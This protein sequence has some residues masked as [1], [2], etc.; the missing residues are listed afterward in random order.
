[1]FE[2]LDHKHR[3]GGY[4][5]V[6]AKHDRVVWAAGDPKRPVKLHAYARALPTTGTWSIDVSANTGRRARKTRVRLAAGKLTLPVPRPACGE[7]G[8]QPLEVW[9][10][11]VEEIDPPP[12][13]EKPLEWVL[14]SNLPCPS[15]G[16]ARR[17]V[18][19][20]ARRPVIEEFHKAQKTGCGIE[21]PQLTDESR[22][23][24]LIALLSIV[25]VFLLGLRDAAG[26]EQSARAPAGGF[27]PQSHLRVLNAWRWQDRDRA[28]TVSEFLLAVARLGGHLNR[29]SDGPPGWLTL[30]RGWQDLTVMVRAADAWER[31]G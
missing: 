12:A 7:H 27:V 6:R 9:V 28:T 11:H 21:L 13:G 20:Y 5:V 18:D 25:G 30:W 2:Y 16:E 29:K 23:E 8:D 19:W 10:V 26:D 1:L 24:P 17:R 31:S 4:Y 3:Q 22:L 15:F 14:L